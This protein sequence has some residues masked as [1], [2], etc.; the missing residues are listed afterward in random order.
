MNCRLVS[1]VSGF[2]VAAVE[3]EVV[4]EGAVGAYLA[5]ADF[6]GELGDEV[7]IGLFAGGGEQVLEGGADGAFV[8][9]FSRGK[10]AELFVVAADFFVRGFEAVRK[11]HAWAVFGEGTRPSDGG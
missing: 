5:A 10:A 3:V 4:A 7:P 8:D 2:P 11:G 6:G 9:D 1:G